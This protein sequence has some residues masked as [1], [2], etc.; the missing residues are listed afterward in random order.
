MNSFTVIV[1]K[2][3]VPSFPCLAFAL[4]W[5]LL[6]GGCATNHGQHHVKPLLVGTTA[7]Y[8]PLIYQENGRM[9][10]AEAVLVERVAARLN[11]SLQFVL[12]APDECPGAVLTREVELWIGGITVEDAERARAGFTEPFLQSGQMILCRREDVGRYRGMRNLNQAGVRVGVRKGSRAERLVPRV[13][14]RAGIAFYADED[15]ALRALRAGERIALYVDDAPV[16]W[17]LASSNEPAM[18]VLPFAL[19]ADLFVWALHPDNVELCEQVN[20]A[21]RLWKEDGTLRAILKDWLPLAR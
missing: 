21:F 9:V 13:L 6:V 11:R 16:I 8:A 19:S 20:R 12:V 5:I 14:P 15:S 10:G 7:Q 18:S 3:R 2:H 1:T 17:R 4:F